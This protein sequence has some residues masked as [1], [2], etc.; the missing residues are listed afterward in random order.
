MP[1]RLTKEM[2]DVELK[3][4]FAYLKTVPPKEYGNR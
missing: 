2:T 3:A 1:Y 4:V